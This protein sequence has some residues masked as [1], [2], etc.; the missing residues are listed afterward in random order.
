MFIDHH[1]ER[2]Y[3]LLQGEIHRLAANS[4]PFAKCS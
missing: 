3:D 4:A 1:H 2:L